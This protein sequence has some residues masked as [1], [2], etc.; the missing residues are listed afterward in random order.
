MG[1]GSLNIEIALADEDTF[2]HQGTLQFLDNRLDPSTGTIN[3]RAVLRNPDG[4]L[5]PGLFVR[6]RLPGAV[7]R[8]GVLVEDRAV[9]TDLDRRFVLVVGADKKVESRTVVLGPLVDGLRVVR[10]GLDAGELV[11]VN[12]LQRV[13]PGMPVNAA[14][15]VMGAPEA[16]AMGGNGGAR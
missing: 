7:T 14:V 3:G 8:K 4:R 2:R 6:L 12:G 16:D 13:R 5:T 1:H 9:G 10:K 11:V 15:A